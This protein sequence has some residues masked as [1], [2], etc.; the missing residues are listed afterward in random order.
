MA[1]A[2]GTITVDD[3]GFPS[4]SGLAFDLYAADHDTMLD[5]LAELGSSNEITLASKRFMA[6]RASAM[7]TAIVTAV[8]A[9]DVR[10]PAN[11]LDTGVPSVTRV[12]AGAVE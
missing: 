9:A 4:G 5:L 8:A 6:A 2:A 3:N 1:L 11:S 10:V 7:A 12:L